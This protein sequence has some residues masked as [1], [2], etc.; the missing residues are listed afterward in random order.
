MPATF[1]T[2]EASDGAHETIGTTGNSDANCHVFSR[3]PVYYAIHAADPHFAGRP[4]PA[5][6]QSRR[7]PHSIRSENS[8]G[9]AMR[10]MRVRRCIRH[11]RNEALIR[12][13]TVR[14]HAA[15]ELAREW[16]GK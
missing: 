15:D 10:P 13:A 7:W 11:I 1:R 16:N 12:V 4:L 14:I 6:R 2:E 9:A 3:S 5:R 8:S